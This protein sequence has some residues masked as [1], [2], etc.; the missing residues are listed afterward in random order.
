[1][2]AVSTPMAWT[3][4]ASELLSKTYGDMEVVGLLSR[5]VGGPQ[6]TTPGGL[7]MGWPRTIPAG[8]HLCLVAAWGPRPG[9]HPSPV[10]CRGRAVGHGVGISP[11]EQHPVGVGE[12]EGGYGGS[13]PHGSFCSAATLS[14]HHLE[15]GRV[16]M[17]MRVPNP[18]H[19]GGGTPTWRLRYLAVLEEPDDVLEAVVAEKDGL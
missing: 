3:A 11:G 18:D 7:V 14:Q 9:L 15:P 8:A 10:S 6:S 4:M 12:R 13:P 17:E 5:G 16:R 19:Q 1:M 2:M